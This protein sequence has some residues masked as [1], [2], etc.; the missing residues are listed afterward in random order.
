MI[1]VVLACEK[2]TNLNLTQVPHL[3][4]LKLC[5]IMEFVR[6][7]IR[8]YEYLPVFKTEKNYHTDLDLECKWAVKKL[9][10]S[11]YFILDLFK[12]FMKKINKMI[13]FKCIKED[14]N[15]RLFLNSQYFFKNSETIS[16]KSFK[17]K[18]KQKIM[19]D[20]TNYEWTTRRRKYEDIEEEKSSNITNELARAINK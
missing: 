18:V 13:Q 16:S 4:R 14:R 12:T 10:S 11:L 5:E 15:L 20:S 7:Q 8:I 6:T 3:L 19:E 17:E 1:L 2:H 9:S